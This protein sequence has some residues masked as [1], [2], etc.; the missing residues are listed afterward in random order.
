MS[1]LDDILKSTKESIL[2]RLSSPLLG[3]FAVAWCAWN[4]RF[5]VILFSN[6]GVT[7]TFDLIEKL[8]FPD[9]WT[10]VGRGFLLPL[11]T[12]L[13]YVFL[14][15][16]PARFVYEFTLR[17][18]REINQTKQRIADETPLTV[19]ESRV[20]R[21]DMLARERKHDE[22]VRDLNEQLNLLRAGGALSDVPKVT[23]PQAARPSPPLTPNI[24]AGQ[25][26][27]L[28]E[29][30]RA[31][32]SAL[33]SRV[34]KA[35]GRSRLEVEHDIDV[36]ANRNLISVAYGAE[37]TGLGFTPQGRETLLA[38]RDAS[39]FGTPTAIAGSPRPAP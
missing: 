34:L 32:G 25:I 3:G 1:L 23:V 27:V 39:K 18:Q 6:A 16:Y 30:D 28:D 9:L 15:P 17:R 5:L 22:Q 38:S 13:V 19:E 29:L 31:G 21:A 36:L 2:E 24:T 26:E 33:Q 12:A 4:Y 35:I 20:L 8:A 7:Q 10:V 11:A 14:Y 37:G